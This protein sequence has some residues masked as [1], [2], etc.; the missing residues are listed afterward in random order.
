MAADE[1]VPGKVTDTGGGSSFLFTSS[2]TGETNCSIGV[3]VG[4]ASNKPYRYQTKATVSIRTSKHCRGEQ[5]N[6]SRATGQ[7]P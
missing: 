4:V 6:G 7:D 2:R 3:G 1:T 5:L